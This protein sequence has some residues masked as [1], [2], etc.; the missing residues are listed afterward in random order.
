MEEQS[1]VL[2]FISRFTMGGRYHE[3]ID[4][5]S[6][7]CCYWFAYILKSRFYSLFPE[8]VYD[9]VANHFGTMIRGRVY[10][11]TGDATERYSWFGWDKLT[12]EDCAK[13]RILRDCVNF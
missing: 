3:V 1:E 2:S 4:S 5:F 8:I 7:G 13:E 10:D 9:P 12:E 11:I 6:C